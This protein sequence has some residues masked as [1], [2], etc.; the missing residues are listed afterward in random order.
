MKGV[1]DSE[2][3]ASFSLYFHHPPVG[4]SVINLFDDYLA[5]FLGRLHQ[6]QPFFLLGG[7][8]RAVGGVMESEHSLGKGV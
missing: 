6:S 5:R 4:I 7:A 3:R 2:R 8:I 1:S